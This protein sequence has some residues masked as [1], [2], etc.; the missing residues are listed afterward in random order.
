MP[1]VRVDQGDAYALPYPDQSFDAAHC[2]RV[3]LHLEDPSTVLREM[4]RVL[5]TGGRMVVAEPD[6]ASL[7]INSPDH[8]MIGLL[9]R[10]AVIVATSEW[11]ESPIA[12][13][14]LDDPRRDVSPV[15]GQPCR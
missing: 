9:V 1:Q 10:N 2:E 6:W 14:G 3:L 15:V 8:E 11:L 4:R 7:I 5:R 13:H 12:T